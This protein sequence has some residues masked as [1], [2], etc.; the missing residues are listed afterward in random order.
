[1]SDADDA[2][3]RSDEC[4][5]LVAIYGEERCVTYDANDGTGGKVVE[6]AI[7]DGWKLEVRMPRGYPSREAPRADVVAR[8]RTTSEARAVESRAGRRIR[9]VWAAKEGEACVFDWAEE[10]RELVEETERALRGDD[11]GADDGAEEDEDEEGDIDGALDLADVEA[12]LEA[13]AASAAARSAA[14]SDGASGRD[15]KDARRA[16]VRARLSSHE[17]VVEKKS[18]FQAHVCRGVKSVEEVDVVMD[19]LYESR[20]VRDATHNILAYRIER[21]DKSESIHQD[22]DD[23][24]ETAA[25]GRLLRLLQLAD[26]RNVVVVVSRWYGGVKLGPSRFHVINETAKKALEALGEIHQ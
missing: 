4:E 22:H 20:K 12:E 19:I 24:G 7:G 10:T 15:A 21:A 2:R 17:L 8:D 9:E 25:G 3:S 1:M 16:D 11:D 18:I 14:A 5:A 13:I 26:A 23:D 6:L